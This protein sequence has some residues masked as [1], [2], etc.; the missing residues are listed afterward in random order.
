M[1]L[2][3]G[4]V[5]V[6]G[7]AG[8]LGAA[9][10]R[11]LHAAGGGVVVFDRD[12]A[13]ASALAEDLGARARSCAGDA[14]DEADM[15]KAVAAAEELGALRGLVACAGGGTRSLRTV[16]RDGS[17]HT[18]D[19]FR[20]VLDTNAVSAFNSLRLAAAAMSRQDPDATGERGAIVLTAS[21]AAY[22]GQI[23]QV[24]Y[25]AAKAAVVGMTLV[26]ARDLA[27]SGIRVNSIAPG[28]IATPGWDA[29]PPAVR[30]RL[31]A[32]VPFP[33]RFGT[34]EEF[35]AAAEHLLTNGYING[36]VLRLDGAVRFDPS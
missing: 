14:A 33:R 35:G 24:A 23:G 28:T 31:E 30:E 2:T 29:A 4:V 32:K 9:T 17:P 20:E 11:R 5:I 21:I 6:T 26:A 27:V 19:L 36:H 12:E 34:P 25:A 10:V 22:E 16:A 7:G 13:R 1:D 3:N 18:L 8:G 15:G